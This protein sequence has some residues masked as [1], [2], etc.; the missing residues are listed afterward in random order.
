[1]TAGIRAHLRAN[2]VGYLALF[3][4]LGGTAYAAATVGS[5]DVIDNSLKSADLKN[6]KAVKSVDVRDDSI[7]GADVDETTLEGVDAA[8][9]DDLPRT[10]YIFRS[11]IASPANRLESMV[12]DSY[13]MITPE[14]GTQYVFGQVKLKTT[15]TAHEF[16]ICGASGLSD[17]INYVLYVEGARTEDSV[18]GD[19]CDAAVN[20]GDSCDFEIAGAGARIWGAPTFIANNNN[21]NL[22]GLKST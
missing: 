2:V 17:P 21:C 7:V 20:F 1:V 14:N 13:V 16:Q 3:V 6:A 15:S 12:F 8:T 18:P 10:E 9:F 4:A 22:I 11:F 19:A 5:G